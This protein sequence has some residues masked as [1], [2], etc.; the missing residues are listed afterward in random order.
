MKKKIIVIICILFLIPIITYLYVY[1]YIALNVYKDNK[2][3]SDAIVVL[4]AQSYRGNVYNACLIGRVS[5]AVDLYKQGYA[6]KIIVSGGTDKYDHTNEAQTMYN[7]AIKQ[8]VKST[9]IIKEDKATS[10]YENLLFT[11]DILKENNMKSLIIVTEPFHSPRA[12]LV[13]NKLNISHTISPAT[14]SPCWTKW[15]FISR[16]IYREPVAIVDYFILGRL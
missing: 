4:G 10:T 11:N 2:V 13:A 3:K 15:K 8:G 1:T 5:H 6:K 14:D 7:L 12:N 16:F 9:D